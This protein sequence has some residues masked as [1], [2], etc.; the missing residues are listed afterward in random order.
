SF[1]ECI[2]DDI[3]EGVTPETSSVLKLLDLFIIDFIQK[4]HESI[5]FNDGKSNFGYHRSESDWEALLVS[6]AE[7]LSELKCSALL[8]RVVSVYL[9]NFEELLDQFHEQAPLFKE[10]LNQFVK[11][12]D[13]ILTIPLDSCKQLTKEICQKRMSEEEASFSFFL[14]IFQRAFLTWAI[15]DVAF[16]DPE[17]IPEWFT[18]EI[19][20]RLMIA[21]HLMKL[22]E[23][24]RVEFISR[25][26]CDEERAVLVE[27]VQQLMTRGIEAASF[28]CANLVE[29]RKPNHQKTD[30]TFGF[31]FK[32]WLFSSATGIRSSEQEIYL[33]LSESGRTLPNA[34][35]L[36]RSLFSLPFLYA[37]RYL[38]QEKHRESSISDSKD[39]PRSSNS[40]EQK[41]FKT[42]DLIPTK[43]LTRPTEKDKKIH[44]YLFQRILYHYFVND[45]IE[46]YHEFYSAIK[47]E[48]MRCLEAKKTVQVNEQRKKIKDLQQRLNSRKATDEEKHNLRSKINEAEE[49]IKEIQG[50]YAHL[51]EKIRVNQERPLLS[52]EEFEFVLSA[53]DNKSAICV[54]AVISKHS[55]N[56]LI[57][58]LSFNQ[59]RS[60]IV[61]VKDR[62][63]RI[64]T[65][66]RPVIPPC[67][68][69]C[70]LFGGSHILWAELT[71]I[72]TLDELDKMDKEK[73][74]QG[75]QRLWGSS[76]DSLSQ[77]PS[78]NIMNLFNRLEILESKQGVH[79]SEVQELAMILKKIWEESDPELDSIFLNLFTRVENLLSRVNPEFTLPTSF[80]GKMLSGTFNQFSSIKRDG[81]PWP[82]NASRSS[83]TA[84]A[85][86]FLSYLFG[87]NSVQAWEA[88]TD[89]TE[90]NIINKIIDEGRAQFEQIVRQRREGH[91]SLVSTAIASGE[92]ITARD[93]LFEHGGDALH[94]S[95]ILN[96]EEK[97]FLTPEGG[98]DTLDLTRER[99]SNT[100]IEFFKSYLD[101]IK[102]SMQ[103][104]DKLGVII[105]C[106]GFSYGLALMKQK[107][108][109]EYV[110]FDSHGCH[111]L[112]GH[113]NAF[114]Y[115][116]ES[117][118]EAAIFLGN[119]IRYQDLELEFLTGRE[120][121]VL[122]EDYQVDGLNQVATYLFKPRNFGAQ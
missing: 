19:K 66:Q 20:L 116:S 34:K 49:K 26:Q 55:K 82:Q 108:T 90:T 17:L 122:I 87:K 95:E 60:D 40:Q 96:I 67:D 39:Q 36:S 75:L 97:F 64:G 86:M 101:K 76:K 16:E 107:D 12:L 33:N 30:L 35:N 42:K 61:K 77:D 62:E 99:S 48:L 56:S 85:L 69:Y 92:T 118:D 38:M 8:N 81:N 84:N 120:K 117:L 22:S 14:R 2:C 115:W 110:I 6:D 72:R 70:Q 111:R 73:G 102:N 88:E 68:K 109:I 28:A 45:K 103:G 83:C 112:N 91:I 5:W 47:D 10:H 100:T 113:G 119:L 18:K 52:K 4:Y 54:E 7:S 63:L 31:G 65:Y 94:V 13:W 21:S 53:L 80:D 29:S 43:I 57:V 1:A 9:D 121:E 98:I 25:F 59:E 24:R 71:R 3:Q 27:K 105:Q 15:E 104:L 114:V 41:H 106:N 74:G 44:L 78:S 51:S 11:N 93:L 58:P 32:G 46:V 89:T 50:F 23:D 37:T 79:L